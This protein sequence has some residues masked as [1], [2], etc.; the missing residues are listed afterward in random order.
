MSSHDLMFDQDDDGWDIGSCS[1]GYDT[2]PVPYKEIAAE[3]WCEH[4]L[5]NMAT[6]M[7]ERISELRFQLDVWA[8]VR[9][10]VLE[11]GLFPTHHNKVMAQ[12]RQE[13]PTL[14]AAIDKALHLQ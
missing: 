12:H 14:W 10:A 5:A 11:K 9:N 13:W 7:S 2:P 3:I 4:V 6:A 8:G 1:C